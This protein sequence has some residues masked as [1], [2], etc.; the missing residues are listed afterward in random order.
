MCAM[1]SKPP[2]A[3][4]LPIASQSE[5]E[6]KRILDMKRPTADQRGYDAEWR[7][8]RARFLQ[9]NPTCT[10]P[11][12]VAKATEVHHVQRVTAA[13]HLR[14]VT[15]NLQGLCKRHHSAITAKEDGFRKGR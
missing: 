11:G 3:G 14:L 15:T 8:T 1:P 6:R 5:R 13:P 12:C 4:S 7:R 10:H 2:R 9:A